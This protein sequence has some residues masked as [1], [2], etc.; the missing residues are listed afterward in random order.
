MKNVFITALK[1]DATWDPNQGTPCKVTIEGS[2]WS[3]FAL[4]LPDRN[5]AP[6]LG[7]IPFNAYPATVVDT[8]N[9]NLC[10]QA[11][12]L[13]NTNPRS[14]ILLHNGNYAGDVTMGY[15]SDVE[16]CFVLGS[17]LGL[18]DPGPAYKGPQLAVLNSRLTVDAFMAET[19]GAPIMVVFREAA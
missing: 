16:G 4:C 12:E 7:R 5:N 8:N 10:P 17:H 9:P 6:D 14:H 3:C 13:Q 1:Q 18:L 11:Y 15:K 2:D 19:Y